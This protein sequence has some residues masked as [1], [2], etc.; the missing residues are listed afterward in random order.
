MSVC[1]QPFLQARQATGEMATQRAVLVASRPVSACLHEHT[2]TPRRSI[3]T[4][5]SL[6]VHHS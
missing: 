6:P 4:T 3:G 5:R 2:P 1:V